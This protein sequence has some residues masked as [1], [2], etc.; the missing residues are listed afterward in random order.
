MHSSA[1]TQAVNLKYSLALVNLYNAAI[2]P[3]WK[4]QANW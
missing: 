4:N 3:E 1:K 2:G